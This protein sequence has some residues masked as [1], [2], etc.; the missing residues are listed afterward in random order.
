MDSGDSD[1]AMSKLVRGHLTTRN[2]ISPEDI[3]LA[4][5]RKAD[6]AAM[7]KGVPQAQKRDSDVI[8]LSSWIYVLQFPN[9]DAPMCR[10]RAVTVEEAVTIFKES[11]LPKESK[12]PSEERRNQTEET[13]AFLE[14]FKQLE[15]FE[16]G[17]KWCAGGRLQ[18]EEDGRYTENTTPASDFLTLLRTVT[19]VK[20]TQHLCLNVRQVLSSNGQYI[21]VLL[22]GDEEDYL[23][24]AERTEFNAQ[25]NVASTDNTSLEPCDMRLRPLRLLTMSGSTSVL[26]K[27]VD[28]LLR[29]ILP[30]LGSYYFEEFAGYPNSGVKEGHWVSY[31]SYLAQFKAGLQELLV[32]GNSLPRHERECYVS[33]LSIRLIEK[34][35]QERPSFPL[36]NL[37]HRL[38]IDLPIGAYTDFCRNFDTEGKD[39][40]APLW[41]T[42]TTNI[43]GQRS[44]FRNSERLEL[45]FSLVNRQVILHSLLKY[46][47][48]A[49]SFPL[50]NEQEL[51]GV[52]D[53]QPSE[54]EVLLSSVKKRQREPLAT[55][56]TFKCWL[57]CRMPINSI[58]NYFGAKIALYFAFTSFVI[59]ALIPISIYGLALFIVQRTTE[60]RDTASIVLNAIFCVLL[61][62]WAIVMLE[63]WRRREATLAFAWGSTDYLQDEVSRPEYTG[64][65]RRSPVTDDLDELF[66]SP[67]KRLFIMLF[68]F[69]IMVIILLIVI[70]I[71]AGLIIMRWKL[72]DDLLINGFDG[73]GPLASVLNAIQIQIFNYLYQEL[74]FKLTDWENHRTQSSYEQSFVLKSFLFQFVNSYNALI[75]IAFI[76]SWTEGCIVK[77]DATGDKVKEIGGPCMDE[78]YTQLTSIFIV[79]YLRNFIELG[80][81]WYLNRRRQKA[82]RNIRF[83]DSEADLACMRVENN[84]YKGTYMTRTVDGTFAD[85][86]EVCIMFG[87]FTI[88]AVAF[89]LG[90]LL[91]MIG[92]L[93]ELRVDRYKLLWMMRRPQPVGAGDIGVWWGI[94]QVTII[95]AIFTNAGIFCFTAQTF[96]DHL[97][98]NEAFIPF[99]IIVVG[100]L[101]IRTWLQMM[102]PDVPQKLH[103]VGQRHD[104]IRRRYLNSWQPAQK[105]P[106]KMQEALCFSITIPS[107]SN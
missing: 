36:A 98:N 10:Q 30:E 54:A 25:L 59:I 77:D 84:Q 99:V 43:P 17:K 15:D 21:Y 107:A 69:L 97:T 66:Y 80:L 89:P 63:F 1:N 88:F 6:L 103:V 5:G 62:I 87:Y 72:T 56:W 94:L 52:A 100:L 11:F 29:S 47:A 35:N 50:H 41:R 20:L 101:G 92:F 79:A 32:S 18:L 14:L 82:F 83:S 3:L 91:G 19:M 24:E 104:N 60:V 86:L 33:K 49:E 13:E 96:K 95:V 12:N 65:P 67:I 4:E 40:F 74:A 7:F 31:E 78:L 37:W 64:R 71:V 51:L 39:E 38:N 58:K 90:C 73:A 16:G 48:L 34:I 75:Y 42:H 9:P 70:G 22:Y 46:Q 106:A 45:I 57:D 81:P 61:P 8:D 85:M 55:K 76:K 27:E 93:L 53:Y 102:I 105:D 26:V 44:I 68:N 2:L 23:A 28:S